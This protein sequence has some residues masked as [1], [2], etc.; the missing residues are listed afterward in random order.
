MMERAVL[1]TGGA[2]F[3]GSHTVE[4]F[5]AN[6]WKVTVLDNFST[7]LAN[8]LPGSHPDLCIVEGSILET[9]RLAELCEGCQAIVHLAAIPSVQRSVETPGETHKVNYVGTLSVAEAA[10]RS[11]VGRIVYA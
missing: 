11:G 1:I 10:R 6:N 9:D 5:L 4:R 7:G 3:I 8:N 2:G